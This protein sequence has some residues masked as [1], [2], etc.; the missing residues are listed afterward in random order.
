MKGN[1]G[2]GGGYNEGRFDKQTTPSPS[3]GMNVGR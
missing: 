2:E 3:Q 1:S